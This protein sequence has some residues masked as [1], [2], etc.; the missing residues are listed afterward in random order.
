MTNNQLQK[1]SAS[2][3]VF[4]GLALFAM[5]FGA[6][7]LI[8]PPD[9]GVRTG[10]D[11]FIGFLCFFIADAGLAI[12]GMIAMVK[13]KG[14]IENVTGTI[15][16]FPA[17]LLNTAVILCIGPGIAIPRTAATT[18][19]LGIMPIFKLGGDTKLIL[20]IF[21]VVFFLI[22][23][24]LTIKPSK[25]V[26]IVGKVLTPILV[27]ALLVMIVVGF[28]SP[29]GE[30]QPAIAGTSTVQFGILNGYQTM[31]GM[32]SL[33][34]AIIVITAIFAKGYRGEKESTSMTIKASGV[35][36]ILL[37]VVY[38]GLAFL[39]ATTGTLWRDGVAAGEVKQAGL[40]IN[41]TNT[42]L[43]N[44]GV[45]ILGVVVALACLTTAIG[46]TSATAEY[47]SNLSKG[48]LKYSHLVILVCVLSA[49]LCNLGLSQI[50][51]VA[52]PVLL[53]VY[54]L[55]VLLMIASLFRNILNKKN[56]Y[57][58]GALVALVV[59][60]ITVLVDVFG[61]TSLN[62]IHKLPLD[63]Y[64]FNWLVPTLIALAIGMIIP[65]SKIE[66]LKSGIEE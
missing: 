54:P 42:L 51:S 19:E 40:L 23:C 25:V 30:I 61:Q 38:G 24:A 43:G 13:A 3:F 47:F 11:W 52:V 10:P 44:A 6:G 62:W 57:R 56:A 16:A 59:S 50:I 12:L 28:V 1:R 26:D 18:F 8:F 32:A 49:F 41:I 5:F 46:L 34:F 14:K 2:D 64:G 37:F 31:D 53:L 9:I 20:G 27:V 39:G 48:K 22:V 36:G 35:A 60:A 33:F 15:G 45:I 7:N 29:K 65:G 66:P 63:E 21:S 17:M 4:I 55:I 58:L